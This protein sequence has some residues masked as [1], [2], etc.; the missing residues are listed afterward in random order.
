MT[1]T[2]LVTYWVSC[3]DNS[4]AYPRHNTYTGT[5][6]ADSLDQLYLELVR[7][8]IDPIGYVDGCGKDDVE[9]KF[10]PILVLEQIQELPLDEQ[11]ILESSEWK[12]HLA[13]LEELRAEELAWK[14]KVRRQY[15]V[16]KNEFEQKSV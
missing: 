1:I 15:E 2:H 13:L 16:L 5:I 3:T 6:L 12:D 9:F 11:R 14:E 7:F 4:Q 10:N 8:R